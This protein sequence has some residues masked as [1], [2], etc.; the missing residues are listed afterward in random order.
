[1]DLP[2]ADYRPLCQRVRL[3]LGV[4]DPL[5]SGQWLALALLD[6]PDEEAAGQVAAVLGE[7]Q[8]GTTTMASAGMPVYFGD[9]ALNLRVFRDRGSGHSPGRAWAELTAGRRGLTCALV[10]VS[11]LEEGDLRIFGG[12]FQLRRT[13]SVVVGVDGKPDFGRLDV[14]KYSL[15]WLPG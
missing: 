7:T 10:V 13:Y 1:M 12:A 9:T 8:N 11:P 3:R 4:V 14:V 6:C 2:F 15:S 5:G